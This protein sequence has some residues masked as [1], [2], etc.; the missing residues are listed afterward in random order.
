[1]GAEKWAWTIATMYLGKFFKDTIAP[2]DLYMNMSYQLG[3]DWNILF[4]QPF[5]TSPNKH[6]ANFF[7]KAVRT[8][9]KL[10]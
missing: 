10:T 5:E 8:Y 6:S 4:Y 2:I 9:T 1:M 7:N 3:V